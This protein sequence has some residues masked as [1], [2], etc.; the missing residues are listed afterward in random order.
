MMHRTAELFMECE[1][2]ELEPW[3]K[4]DKEV[5]DDDDDEPIFVGEITASKVSS[6]SNS[7]SRSNITATSSSS[8]SSSLSRGVQN[9]APNKVTPALYNSGT[10]PAYKPP[11]QHY[12][13]PSS[14]PGSIAVAS[15]YQ[16][17][18]RFPPNSVAPQQLPR[19]MNIS[20]QSIHRSMVNPLS[21][22]TVPRS[23]SV[24][25]QPLNRPISIPATSQ[26]VSRSITIPIM[27]QPVPRQMTT[28]TSQPIILNQGYIMNS[29][30]VVP[31]SQTVMYGLRHSSGMTQYA[32]GPTL[33]VTGNSPQIIRPL[34]PLTPTRAAAPPSRTI[35]NVVHRTVAQVISPVQKNVNMVSTG[36]MASSGHFLSAGHV[37]SG[38]SM[39]SSS[40]VSSSG[41]RTPVGHV[42]S[43]GHMTSGGHKPMA[44]NVQKQTVQVFNNAGP[45]ENLVAPKRP[46]TSEI[47]SITP[48]KPKPN[49]AAPAVTP[50]PGSVKSP[51][52]SSSQNV[53]KGSPAVTSSQ[54]KN[55]VPFP[56][57]CPKCNIH[58]NLMDP[59][60]NH[61]KYCCPDMLNS[62]FPGTPKQET[63]NT[64]N[65]ASELEKGKLIMLVSDFYY[66]KHDGD[67]NLIHQEQKTHTT[68]KC[69]SCLK[70]LKNNV[71][72]MNHM[73]HHLELEKQSTETWENHT[74]CH[75]CYR[76]FSSPF[77]LQC[78]VESAHS[79]YDTT[80]TCKICELN[81]ETEQVLLQHMKDCHKP[82]EMPYVCQVCNYRSSI[83]S[84]VENHFRT[85]HENTKNLLCPF[86]LKVIK[87]GTP[88]MQH[89]MRHQKKGIY[90]CTKCRLQFLTCKEKMDHKT[91]HHRTFRKPKQL[92]GLPPGTKVTIRASVGPFQPGSPS[93]SSS[94]TASTSALQLSSNNRN[95]NTKVNSST[96]KAATPIQTKSL[97][98][99]QQKKQ[100]VPVKKPKVVNTAL[101]SLR[102]VTGLHKCIECCT[103]IKD[104]ASH[105]PSLVQC[106][107]CK[108]NTSCS[109]AY[110]NHM[111]SFHSS[112]PNKR[113]WIFKKYSDKLRGITVVCL[114]CDFLTDVSGLDQMATHLNENDTHTC[115]VIV[116]SVSLCFPLRPK[117]AAKPVSLSSYDGVL[118]S[119]RR[120]SSQSSSVSVSVLESSTAAEDEEDQKVKDEDRV[121]DS[122]K[123]ET[124]DAPDRSEMENSPVTERSVDGQEV[125]DSKEVLNPGDSKGNQ[126]EPSPLER[127]IEGHKL[128]NSECSDLSNE[129]AGVLDKLIL[130]DEK[131]PI[132]EVPGI[133]EMAK[134]PTNES[135]KEDCIQESEERTENMPVEE[136]AIKEEKDC[137]STVGV[138]NDSKEEL[139]TL[140]SEQMCS[141]TS[142]TE[143]LDAADNENAA[144]TCDIGDEGGG[145][146]DDGGGGGGDDDK[147]LDADDVQI[148]EVDK[149]VT[150]CDVKNDCQST[151]DTVIKD[152][153]VEE[154]C[155]SEPVL[156]A[157]AD[158]DKG[159][160]CTAA[161]E[162][163]TF[164]QFLRKTDEPESL[165]SDV[166][167]QGSV[168]LE[169]LTPSEVLEHETT[170][171]L[172]KGS[173][174]PSKQPE[175]TS[176]QL[177]DASLACSPSQAEV[178]KD[179]TEDSEQEG[180]EN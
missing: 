136:N 93:P 150:V 23:C 55:G 131:N 88:F 15:V 2:E 68:F 37:S 78:H 157:E 152:E 42:T 75:H 45:K 107:L 148:V 179:K 170:E 54:V 63:T 12:M 125:E 94:S 5:D 162:D 97:P 169:P 32:A 9:G 24:T 84:D 22:Q 60:K 38:G 106:S 101:Q 137:E 51:A 165:S 6:T 111:M 105:F 28:A 138:E 104:F 26:Q 33:T 140:T 81:F 69:F 34:Q 95:T 48:K 116:E 130:L 96:N 91:Q 65:K 82:G 99:T 100:E 83:F 122:E 108:Y 142:L 166:S 102:N 62:F 167:D 47:N 80:T 168:H 14:S 145:E 73:K 67:A 61:M 4:R 124:P 56:R 114:N 27:A 173:S 1:E 141:P 21:G 160:D 132:P 35:P 155:S 7:L 76:Q 20:A 52:T 133:E 112:S 176:D 57:A 79:P 36:H 31:N 13:I 103:E 25:S 3:Q 163:V 146:D 87:S 44:V 72:F 174:V 129:E 53:S 86:C 172:Q 59:L 151:D 18:S 50:N 178:A 39:I 118:P 70:I 85:A 144:A 161:E 128:E 153:A 89:Y 43:G 71:R 17:S 117:R 119:G 110:V 115:Q 156:A 16:P 126:P 154:T 8:S 92:E 159:E 90:R 177:D 175:L 171:I 74:S 40:N 134:S 158:N 98:L 64:P 29:A 109:K 143:N 41:S 46:S 58:F 10:V 139:L 19:P 149:T 113:F 121:E 127:A 164:E 147:K 30:Q 49:E 77:Q 123:N 66:G 180:T 120:R 11:S 135:K